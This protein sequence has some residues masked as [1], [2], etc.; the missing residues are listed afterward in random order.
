M[1]AGETGL[2]VDDT[3]PTEAERMIEALTCSGEMAELPFVS[4]H[5]VTSQPGDVDA[6]L[7][8]VFRLRHQRFR[9]APPV[10]WWDEPYTF[11]DERGFFQNSFVFAD[12]LLSDP[13][14]PEVLVP[15][16]TLLLDWLSANPREGAAHPHRYAWHDHAA[17]GRIVI[18]AFVLREGIRRGLLERTITTAL[19]AGVIEH[20][21]YLLADEN[22]AAQHN[23]GFASDAALM[24]AARSL[25]P[26]PQ[27]KR[28][29]QVA[30]RRFAA[31]LAHMIDAEEALH[32][33]HSPYYHWIIHGALSRFAAAG[34]FEGQDLARLTNRMEEAGAW[35][36]APDGT[37]PPI[38]DTPS[39]QRPTR[40][41]AAAAASLSGMRVF[42]S[43]GYAVVRNGDSGLI[44]TA[45]HHPTA[46]KHSDD[47]SFCLYE[48]GRP[49]VLDSG[50]PGYEYDGPEFRYGTSPAAHA[51]ICVDGFD[52]SRENPAYGSG[53]LAAA[54]R[55][56]L[57]A[58][59][60]RNPGAVPGGGVARRLLV[61]RPGRFLLVIDDVEA[62]A[63][64][65]IAR[66][67][68]LA[69]DLEAS[70]DGR[71][72]AEISRQGSTVASLIQVST[73]GAP[74]D[75]ATLT[76][77][78]RL[79]EMG[80]FSFPTPD[81]PR[82]S[83]DLALVG[84]GG[85]PRAYALVLGNTAVEVPDMSWSTSGRL[86]DVEISGLADSP[87]AIRVGEATVELAKA[88]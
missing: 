42:K 63:E 70:L 62:G 13:R 69:P 32:L 82:A 74:S 72:G 45:A 14:F 31:I 88:G 39:G 64:R 71:G 65:Q 4:I 85:H 27:V 37:L 7:D 41:A 56:G 25:S 24:L 83:F 22:Y 50:N 59:L 38:G 33:E 78:R 81:E 67:L 53:M 61:Y 79:P 54:E 77:E 43:A 36:V 80:G 3:G 76:R 86:I 19:A 9:L 18:M 48:R 34:L 29:A 51:T 57:Y 8:G 55:N 44:V 11:P 40:A 26:A 15:L 30:E 1:D 68:P 35:L 16:A 58:L 28:W 49:I 84:P 12:P 73:G 75:E 5:S 10:D 52:W 20:A 21:E 66:Y 6:A 2:T 60:T 46:H 47:G 87:V 23:H 17:A